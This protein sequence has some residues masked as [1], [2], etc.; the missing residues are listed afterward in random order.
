[1]LNRLLMA[2]FILPIPIPVFI[3]L[4]SM[5]FIWEAGFGVETNIPVP[6]GL[7]SMACFMGYAAMLSFL[8]EKYSFL[9]KRGQ[10]ATLVFFGVLVFLWFTFISNLEISR[11]LQL[12][13]PVFLLGFILVPRKQSDV[14]E[15]NSCLTLSA[16]AFFLIHLFHVFLTSAEVLNPTK[17]EFVNFFSGSIYQGLVS[18]PSVIFIYATLFFYNAFVLKKLVPANTVFFVASICL[19]AMASRKAS[20]I[21]IALLFFVPSGYLIYRSLFY[22]SIRLSVLRIVFFVFLLIFL[23]AFVFGFD[24]P[25]INR[26]QYQLEDGVLDSRT[27]K[28]DAILD[29]FNSDFGLF[30]FG[31]GGGGAPGL[32]N[33]IFDTMYRVGFFGVAL[34][35]FL[36]F[37]VI[38][39]VARGV[40]KKVPVFGV[41]KKIFLVVLFGELFIQSTFN[42][43]MTQPYLV[44]NILFSVIIVSFCDAGRVFSSGVQN[45]KNRLLRIGFDRFR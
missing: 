12:L 5:S 26:L 37:F 8:G 33:Y 25:I 1:M 30:L 18:Y 4:K 20:F 17:Y 9:M 13:L 41:L 28:W 2:L 40:V 39:N 3:D 38:Y 10:M 27:E 21:S 7:L 23:V 44:V 16:G 24:L 35:L 14:L 11:S 45:E 42:S 34:I 43:G 32:H 29:I 15:M 22:F 31:S 6:V 19:L 36:L